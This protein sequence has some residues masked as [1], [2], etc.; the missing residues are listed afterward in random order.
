M[1]KNSIVKQS[2]VS[3]CFPLTPCD[4]WKMVN[5]VKM[6]YQKQKNPVCNSKRILSYKVN[7]GRCNMSSCALR[8]RLQIFKITEKLGILQHRGQRKIPFFRVK[9]MTTTVI[10]GNN[11]SLHS[12]VNVSDVSPCIGYVVS[13]NAVAFRPAQKKLIKRYRSR[14]NATSVYY[15]NRHSSTFRLSVSQP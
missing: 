9:N 11:H 1:I 14:R 2:N 13:R 6:F 3:K 8:Q 12:S 10:Q 7:M 5:G 15:A 4:A